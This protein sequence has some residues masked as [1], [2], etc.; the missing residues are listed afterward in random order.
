MPGRVAHGTAHAYVRLDFIE[1]LTRLGT[2]SVI[3]TVVDLF[4]NYCHFIP[5]AYPYSDRIGGASFLR[6]D[7]APP[8]RAP[9]HG[10]R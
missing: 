9:V 10:L 3:L 7:C 2:K 8:W 1:A 6:R 4:S 5:L